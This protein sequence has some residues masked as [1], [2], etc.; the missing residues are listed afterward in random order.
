MKAKF[1]LI[2]AAAC[3]ALAAC[4]KN[5]VAPVDVDQEITFQT[6]ETKAAVGFN[7]DHAFYSWAY[8]LEE[9]MDWANNASD[10]IGY[11]DKSVITWDGTSC[12]K[13]SS[14][15]YYW[16]KQGSLTFFAWSDD[17]NAPS[18]APATVSCSKSTGIK[19]TDYDITTVKNKDLLVAKIANDKRA[20]DTDGGHNYNTNT[21]A[22]GV[23]TEFYHVLSNLVFTAQTSDTYSGVTFKVN[24][25][26]I[27]GVNTK[28]TYSQGI[29]SSNLPT[30]VNYWTDLSDVENLP[31]YSPVTP[32]VLTSSP[33]T[34]APKD[35]TDYYIV[36]PQDL[37]DDAKIVIK[38]Q[39]KTNY[40]I[41]FDK[42][43]TE[44]KTLNTIYNQEWV[45]GKKY[46]VNITFTLDEILWDPS[47]EEWENGS[48]QS[49]TL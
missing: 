41:E 26:E 2:A 30:S 28:G 1:Y 23:N 29:S 44:E 24:S 40:G 34:L 22:T 16:P 45:S 11:I 21:W 33:V 32:I 5:E 47:V 38:Y 37:P 13:N 8:F 25:I 27:Q 4:S 15:T 6:I 12:W 20:N 42:V 46:T 48:T 14:T 19:F 49:I 18:V 35:G 9:G 17:T 3:A 39:Y 36:L 31:V 43:F 10:A 7:T